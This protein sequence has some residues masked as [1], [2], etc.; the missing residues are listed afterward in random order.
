MNMLDK[1]LSVV[2][3]AYN[4]GKKL[5]NTLPKIY[6]YLKKQSYDWEILIV[7]DGSKDNTADVVKNLSS[8]IENLRLIDN[9]ENHGKG[10]VV[11]QGMLSARGKYRVFT[12]ADNSTS[13]D[14]VEKMWPE[15]ERGYNVIIGSRDI[16]GAKLAVPQ[17]WWRIMV[18]NVF[19]L[20]VQVVCGL[21]GIPDTQ[22]GFKGFTEKAAEDI[23]SRTRIS[24]FAFD[25]E[26]L[27]IAKTMKYKIKQIP[28]FWVNDKRSSVKFKSMLKMAID[29]LKIRLNMVKGIYE[30]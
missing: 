22:C 3:P 20:M 9:K 7:N 5:P 15:F 30:K 21:W 25:A 13:I 11:K 26:M 19:N 4:E 29:L 10:Y 18:G 14:H 12:D 28:V 6:D 2:I 27:V 23:F 17:P 24:R 16:E 1:H 8:R